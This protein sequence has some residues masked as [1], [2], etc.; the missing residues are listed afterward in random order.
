MRLRRAETSRGASLVEVLVAMTIA[1][2]A[3]LGLAAVQS[4][5]LS[6]QIDS[7]NRRTATLLVAQMR[8]RVSANQEGYGKALAVA[9]AYNQTLLPGATVVV[10]TCA[11]TTACNPETEVPGILVAQWFTELQRQLPGAAAT[12]TPAVA[13]TAQAMRVTVGWI[14]PNATTFA[15]DGACGTLPKA[16]AEDVRYRCVTQILFPG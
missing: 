16:Q 3:L 7:E 10:P 9:G 5:S 4:R 12:I 8:E 1:G 14:E 13:G 15:R 11:Q 2:V 6:L